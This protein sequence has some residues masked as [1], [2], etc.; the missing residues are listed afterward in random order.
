MKKAG[1]VLVLVTLVL[2]IFTCGFLLGRNCNRSKIVMSGT[3]QANTQETDPD[4]STSGGRK[5]NINTATADELTLLPGI[6]EALA[7]RILEYRTENGP[8]RSTEDL[9][10]VSGIGA[11]KLEDLLEHITIGGST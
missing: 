7:Q 11:Q 4:T 1:V 9:V 10:N 2:G 6:G 5:V 3:T 8:F